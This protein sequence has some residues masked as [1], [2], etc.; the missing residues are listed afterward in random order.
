MTALE[1][2][3]VVLSIAMVLLN[4]RVHPAAWPLAIASSACYG[5]LFWEHRLYGD[6]TLQLLF[7]AMAAW[8]WWQW[9][10]GHGDGGAPLVVRPLSRRG[11][12]AAVAAIAVAWPAVGL[13]LKAFTDSDLPWWD[14]FPTA[15]SV[16][17]TVLLA[18]KHVENWPVWLVVN[19][20]ATGLFAWKALWLTAGLYAAFVVLSVLGWRAWR[21][22]AARQAVRA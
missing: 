15:A 9:L 14:A 7:I 8:G 10:R 1:V 19:V 21:A 18:R 11:R 20:V 17:G 5:F 3:A 4:M 22:L 16:V 2:V 13:V 12:F 6:A